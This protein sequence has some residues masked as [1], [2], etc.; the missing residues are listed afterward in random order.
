V[1]QRQCGGKLHRRRFRLIAD[2]ALLTL[3]DGSRW[4][5]AGGDPLSTR[6]VSCLARIA[7]ALPLAG[8]EPTLTVFEDR[9]EK[10]RGSGAGEVLTLGP[11][12]DGSDL[13]QQALLVLFAVVRDVQARGG[14]LV[15]GALAEFDGD[16]VVLAGKS[17]AGKT[18][19]SRRLRPPWRSFCDDTTLLL[20]D[21]GGAWRAHP[22]PTA[23]DVPPE[24]GVK[25]WDVQ[26]SAPLRG[27]FFLE[28]G[29]REVS[30]RLGEAEALCLLV[31][32][33]EQASWP[34]NHGW[35][36]EEEKA[37]EQRLQR[38]DNLASLVRD[39]PS[40]RLEVSP[41]GPFWKTI[42]ETLAGK[43]APSP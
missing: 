2:G 6:V 19:A 32:T 14:A 30:R 22:W 9:R 16:G 37:R 1:R 31:E 42:E 17:E 18:T 7:R 11:E 43:R 3:A 29:S 23:G 10:M 13:G 41:S 33:A 27:I 36:G 25:S 26:H 5:I 34:L 35:G 40:H 28:Q 24:G 20:R 12:V 21:A 8:L 15:H 39:V 4:A 38:F